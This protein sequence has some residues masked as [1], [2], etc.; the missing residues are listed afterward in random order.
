[1]RLALRTYQVPLSEQVR[2]K[3]EEISTLKVRDA[4]TKTI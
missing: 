1:M 3:K 4:S 2:K